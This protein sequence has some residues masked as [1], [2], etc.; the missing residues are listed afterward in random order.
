MHAGSH[1]C[2]TSGGQGTIDCDSRTR[3]CTRGQGWVRRAGS[4]TEPHLGGCTEKRGWECNGKRIEKRD[5]KPLDWQVGRKPEP[6]DPKMDQNRG[7]EGKREWA[8]WERWGL[9]IQCRQKVEQLSKG[10]PTTLL[11]PGCESSWGVISRHLSL[12]FCT[13][14]L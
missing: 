12:S 3:K 5:R 2:W 6:Y 8:R 7:K 1:S 9:A 13:L 11:L 14:L 10:R 4:W